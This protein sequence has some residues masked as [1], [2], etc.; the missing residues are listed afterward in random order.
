MKAYIVITHEFRPKK[1][2]NTSEKGWMEKE[3]SMEMVEHVN[4]V[5]RV[6]KSWWN[7]ATT[8]L[9]VTD[10]KVVKNNAATTDFNEIIDH[11]QHKYPEH[12]LSFMKECLKENL[13]NPNS[14]VSNRLSKPKDDIM[15][16]VSVDDIDSLISIGEMEK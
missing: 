13:I 7:T 3:N 1:G 15:D 2:V 5:T 8:I 16:T 4:F 12:F 6:R 14:N 10:G 11:V 9:N